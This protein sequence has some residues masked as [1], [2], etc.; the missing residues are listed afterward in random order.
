MKKLFW[1]FLVIVI[2]ISCSA[3]VTVEPIDEVAT[4]ISHTPVSS[5]V[6][7]T[8]TS[9]PY[10]VLMYTFEIVRNGK[11]Y[12]V[13]LGHDTGRVWWNQDATTQKLPETFDFSD[14]AGDVVTQWIGDIDNDGETEYVLEFIFCGTYCSSD[15]RVLDYDSVADEYRVFANLGVYY[16]DEYTDLN[17]DGRLEIITQDYDFHFAVGGAGATR[18]LAPQKIY[19]YNGQEFFAVTDQYPDLIQIE[20]DAALKSAREGSDISEFELINYLYAMYLLGQQAE[21]ERVFLE[22]CNQFL[23]P[24]NSCEGYLSDIQKVLVDMKIG[25]E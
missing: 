11:V 19:A 10:G 8:A 17:N 15:L 20:A 7:I 22:V 5:E 9:E 24:L 18:G 13:P 12:H 1:S 2:A 25:S 21:G 6:T 23:S 4:A 16:V 3:P 14:N